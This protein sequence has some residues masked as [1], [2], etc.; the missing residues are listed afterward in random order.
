MISQPGAVISERGRVIRDRGG[1][2]SDHGGAI[3]DVVAQIRS[4]G[5]AITFVVA[6]ISYPGEGISALGA[7]ISKTVARIRSLGASISALV[8]RVEA[9]VKRSSCT[10]C[11][12]DLER[13]ESQDSGEPIAIEQFL[14]P[15]RMPDQ[16]IGQV[17]MAV[18][19]EQ[20]ARFDRPEEPPAA[21]LVEPFS[22][23][24]LHRLSVLDAFRRSHVTH[25]LMIDPAVL[26]DKQRHVSGMRGPHPVEDP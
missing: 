23:P 5:G 16:T 2:I 22:R 1:V 21:V 11:V 13:C 10:I 20:V 15:R 8:S 17:A 18:G 14:I 4:S 12:P 6:A 25:L 7:M 3:S 24:D 26:E 9:R 19:H